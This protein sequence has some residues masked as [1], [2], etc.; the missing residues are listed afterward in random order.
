MMTELES[1]KN[2]SDSISALIKLAE[3]IKQNYDVDIQN[4][5]DDKSPQFI[6]KKNTINFIIKISETICIMQKLLKG[7]N[8]KIDEKTANIDNEIKAINTSILEVGENYSCLKINYEKELKIIKAKIMEN[9]NIIKLINSNFND[10]NIAIENLQTDSDAYVTNVEMI[11]QELFDQQE[12]FKNVVQRM[13]NLIESQTRFRNFRASTPGFENMSVINNVKKLKIPT[14][15]NNEYDK[16]LKYLKEIEQY[17]SSL[18]P[19]K[20]KL[21]C[22]LNQSLTNNANNWWHVVENKIENMADFITIFKNAFWNSSVRDQ[23]HRK[24][25]FGRYNTLSNMSCIQY[26]MHLAAM[27]TDLGMSEQ[28]SVISISKH[29]SREVKA[30]ARSLPEKT[31]DNLFEILRDVDADNLKYKNINRSETNRESQTKSLTPRYNS[32]SNSNNNINRNNKPNAQNNFLKNN[33]MNKNKQVTMVDLVENS[34]EE[35]ENSS[36]N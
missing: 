11:K 16:P 33:T 7:L 36:E 34:T 22:I 29:F 32:A 30:Y 21:K 25:S 35:I 6:E 18:N 20:I 8:K 24:I 28:E 10:V 12:L 4:K 27:A 13:D 23:Y 26:A 14:F 31:Y 2:L 17:M 1:V 9:D 3:H 15:A 19:D 5:K